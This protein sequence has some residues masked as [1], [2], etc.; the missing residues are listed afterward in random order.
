MFPPLSTEQAI[1]RTVR[2]E[3]GRI[4][5]SLVAYLDDIQLAEDCLQDAFVSAMSHWSKNGLPRSPAAWLITVARRKALDRVRRAQ[6]FARKQD[7][8]AY[9][10]EL[11]KQTVE[12]DMTGPI[13]D[14]RLEMI[15][16][17]CHPAL[18]AKSQVALTLR[19][20]GGLSTEDIASAFLDKTDAM[21]QRITRAKKKIARAGIPYEVPDK[22]V[23]QARTASVLS[24]L[25]LIFNEGYSATRGAE[26]I[27]TD[28]TAEAIRLTR[29][30][31][32]LL[33]KD[34]EVSGLLALMLLHDSRRLSRVGPEGEMVPLSAQN[35]NRWDRE[36]ILEGVA[37]L[38]RVL[39]MGTVGP[40]QVQAAISAVHA[41]SPDWERTDWHEISALYELLYTL[42]PSAVI[43]MNHAVAVSYSISVEA[44]LKIM[45]EVATDPNI[46]TYQP[47]YAALA[48][49]QRRTGDTTAARASFAAA[50]SL[51]ANIQE[52][53][54]LEAAVRQL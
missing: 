44:A 22:D 12:A 10:L 5:A 42:Q 27:R 37:I 30:V 43:R 51:T 24:V 14:K 20:L 11:E 16:T 4:L 6:R 40:Y 34:T 3:W 35:R 15:F 46:E 29:I 8:I 52:K 23:L 53:A 36:K 48:D 25:Y 18:D 38:E 17:C 21:Q 33:P 19:T 13:P 7:D 9:L 47:Y 32:L 45:A 2:E 41:Q 49:L 1:D 39:P 31:S 26:L 54:F 50:I 28:I